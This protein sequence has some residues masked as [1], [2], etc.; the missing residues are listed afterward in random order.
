MAKVLG[1]DGLRRSVNYLV[2]SCASTCGMVELTAY[3]PTIERFG[4]AE[5]M[6]QNG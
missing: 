6:L 2:G 3:T 5:L 1:D 4:W